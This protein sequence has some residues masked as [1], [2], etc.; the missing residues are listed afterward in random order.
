M[1]A[2]NS[3]KLTVKLTLEEVMCWLEYK[4]APEETNSL[5]EEV[6]YTLSLLIANGGGAT[7]QI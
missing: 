6:Y 2:G 1:Q 7:G 4:L 5:G 3:L